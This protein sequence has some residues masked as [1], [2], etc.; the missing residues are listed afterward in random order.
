MRPLFLR[1]ERRRAQGVRLDEVIPRQ[2]MMAVYVR[3]RVCVSRRA[4]GSPLSPTPLAV[5][6][7]RVVG[8]GLGLGLGGLNE[9]FRLAVMRIARMIREGEQLGSNHGETNSVCER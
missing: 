7:A 8:L 9:S 2:R 1:L 3:V 6:A 5:T 4:D